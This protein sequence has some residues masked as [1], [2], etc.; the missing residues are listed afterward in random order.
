MAKKH[1]AILIDAK[2]N[3]AVA[4]KELKKGQKALVKG[5]DF[6]AEVELISDIAF[7]HKFAIMVLEGETR[8]IKYGEVIG[9]AKNSI[10]MGEHVH[11]HNIV[12]IRGKRILEERKES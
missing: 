2:D 8:I 3:V 7:G 5:E 9:K 4:I 12:G 11:D 10:K 6:S 1:D